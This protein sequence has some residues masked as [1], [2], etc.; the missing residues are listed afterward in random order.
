VAHAQRAWFAAPVQLFA[1]IAL[2]LGLSMDTAAVALSVGFGS[3]RLSLR[4]AL[5]MACT[6]GAFHVVMPLLG[7]LIGTAAAR[8]VSA[9]DH[10]IAFGLLVFVGGKMLW[11]ALERRRARLR[12]DRPE[13]RPDAF[14]FGALLTLAFATSVDSLGAGFSLPLLGVHIALAVSIVGAV[15]FTVTLCSL[16]VGK[17]SGE[18]FGATLDAIGGLVLIVIGAMILVQHSR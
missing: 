7:V 14:H 5:L 9:I 11:E 18:R 13:A 10:W 1:V 17:R 15:T 4:R 16:Y 2:A 12:G 6:F 3:P 8:W